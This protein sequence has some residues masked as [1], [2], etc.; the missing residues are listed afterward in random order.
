MSKAKG[1]GEGKKKGK[2][3]KIAAIVA[4]GLFFAPLLTVGG[5]AIMLSSLFGGAETSSSTASFDPILVAAAEESSGRCEAARPEVLIAAVNVE[6]PSGLGG[7]DPI[8]AWGATLA[9]SQ[10]YETFRNTGDPDLVPTSTTSV[11]DA[12][13]VI[14]CALHPT[15]KASYPDTAD[16]GTFAVLGLAVSTVD[17]VS[18]FESTTA[19]EAL[20]LDRFEAMVVQASQQATVDSSGLGVITAGGWTHPVPAVNKVWG[21]YGTARSGYTHAGEDL[22]APMGAPLYAAADG[23]VTGVRC[24]SW[25]GRSPCNILIDVGVTGSGE[26]VQLLYVHMYPNG[27]HVALGDTI[28]VGQHIADVGSNGNSTGPHLHLEVWLDGAVVNPTTFFAD[29]GIDLKRPEVKP[30]PQTPVISANASGALDWARTQIGKPYVWAAAGPDSYDCSGLT[31]RAFE[32]AGLSI[33]R[34]SRAQY[35]ATARV[36]RAS[37]QAG[38]LVF[39]SRNG[40]ASGIYHVAIYA[41]KD[42]SGRDRIVQAPSPGQNVNEVNLYEANLF[43]FG[44]VTG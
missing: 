9:T 27:V 38:D 15:M 10:Q 7:V 26:K 13:A 22:S 35:D 31:M 19:L 28:T 6:P 11:V 33:P 37:L 42:A 5:L 1:Q 21:N 25:K 43:G 29:Q 40:N 8:M 20:R 14:W 4:V 18:R 23:V 41:G 39:W 24:E 32:N 36:D 2:K 30:A 34:N 44:R 17:A 12:I 16:R 3:G